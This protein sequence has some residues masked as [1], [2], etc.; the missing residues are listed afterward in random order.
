MIPLG[1]YSFL[2]QGGASG[3]VRLL[4]AEISDQ[5]TRYF[6]ETEMGEV[7]KAGDI[8]SLVLRGYGERLIVTRVESWVEVI[9]ISATPSDHDWAPGL[10]TCT[11]ELLLLDE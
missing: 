6:G 1:A 10:R 7:P 2:D 5:G 11:L 4:S 8:L 9:N 3:R